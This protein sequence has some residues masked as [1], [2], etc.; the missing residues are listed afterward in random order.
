MGGQGSQV[1][2]L[3]ADPPQQVLTRIQTWCRRAVTVQKWIGTVA[4]KAHDKAWPD[5]L[6]STT[7]DVRLSQASC[8]TDDAP[9]VASDD[10]A[11]AR[12]SGS[13]P[14]S[15]AASKRPRES[16][17]SAPPATSS[18]GGLKRFCSSRPTLGSPGRCPRSAEGG[19]AA[20]ADS[21]SEIVDAV[22]TFSGGGAAASCTCVQSRKPWNTKPE[23]NR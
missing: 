4:A 14:L 21:H 16:V 7:E 18:E 1:G 2:C 20:E 6:P 11:D 5:Y 17:D 9:R 10:V 12:N 8:R 19:A 13:S 22:P 3:R 23:D 15:D